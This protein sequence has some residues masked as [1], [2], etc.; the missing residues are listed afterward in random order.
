MYSIKPVP[1][2]DNYLVDTEGKVWHR[3]TKRELAFSLVRGYQRAS[4]YKHPNKKLSTVHRLVA[5]TFIPNPENKPCVNHIDCDKFNNRVENLEWVTHSENMYHAWKTG[6]R[7]RTQKGNMCNMGH[8]KI[9]EN[10]Y[11]SKQGVRRCKTCM[12][13]YQANYKNIKN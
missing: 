3:A 4:L 1:E 6:L 2:Y 9:D 13:S 7:Q 5:T 12:K 10:V 8:L 11:I